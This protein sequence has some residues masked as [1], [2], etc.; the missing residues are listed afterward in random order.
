[1]IFD[2]NIDIDVQDWRVVDDSVMGG[3]SSGKFYINTQGHGVFEGKVSL[4]NNGGFSLLRYCFNSI[5]TQSY[6]KIVL[7]I[8]GDGRRYQFRL[9]H[10]SSDDYSYVSYFQS[11][12]EWQT[13]EIS[14]T[15]MYPAF[16]GRTLNIPNYNADSIEEIA[17]LIG[18][19]KPENFRLEIDRIALK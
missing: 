16:R 17:F 13:V 6:S 2:F 12:S 8:K 18:N 11:S 10:R 3:K 4:E 7:N 19:K 1:M 5:S 15:D 14:L 9:K